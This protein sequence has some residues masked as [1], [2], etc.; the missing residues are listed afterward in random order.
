[1]NALIC[2]SPN[3]RLNSVRIVT[4][5]VCMYI[6]MSDVCMYAYMYVYYL[7]YGGVEGTCASLQVHM[8][9]MEPEMRRHD[10]RLA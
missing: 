8:I 7:L 10:G 5:Y 6:C 9:H 3:G 2:T 1:M 4:G